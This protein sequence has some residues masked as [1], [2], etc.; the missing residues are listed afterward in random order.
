MSKGQYRLIRQNEEDQKRN[1]TAGLDL[2][3]DDAY[4]AKTRPLSGGESVMASLA[5]VLGSS[6]VVQ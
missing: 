5:L 2:A 4:T 6:D 1:I 3:I